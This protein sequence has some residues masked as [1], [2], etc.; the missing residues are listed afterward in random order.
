MIE[1]FIQKKENISHNTKIVTYPDGTG[2]VVVASLP[3]F[4]EAG[5]ENV[6]GR[7]PRRRAAEQPDGEEVPGDTL[8]ARRRAKARLRDLAR[9]NG[10]NVFVTFTLDQK[11]IDRYD[12]TEITRKLNI[13]LDNRVRR[14]GLKYVLVPELHKDGAIHFHGLCNDVLVRRDSG[15]KTKQGRPVYNLPDW[16]Y[17]FTTAVVIPPD[18]Y[19]QTVSYVTKYVTKSADKVGGRWFYSGGALEQPEVSLSDMD[20]GDFDARELP[21]PD[22]GVML[23][24]F[25]F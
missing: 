11:R 23:K 19:S 7:K 5:W 17:G 9:A 15:H 18:E 16:G 14:K 22:A 4:R 6:S 12:I 24:C 21:V 1:S 25:E 10:L 13:W 8:R 2:R 3:I 20:Y